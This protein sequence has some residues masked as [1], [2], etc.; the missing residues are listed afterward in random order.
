MSNTLIEIERSI[1][2]PHF[3]EMFYRESNADLAEYVGDLLE[4]YLLYGSNEMRNPNSQFST[5]TYVDNN[6]DII[7]LGLNPF[8]HYLVSTSIVIPSGYPYFITLEE[9]Q[10]YNVLNDHFDSNFYRASNP[11]LSM[12]EFDLLLHFIRVGWR[13]HRNPNSMFNTKFYLNSYPDISSSEVNP[14]YHYICHGRS[15]GRDCSP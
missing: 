15:E 10:I 2:G 1:I 9:S 4:H 7:H 5:K 12:A 13:E 11:D 3:N 6:P 8:A 14:F